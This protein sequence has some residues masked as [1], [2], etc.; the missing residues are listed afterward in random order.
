ML[1]ELQVG[2]ARSPQRI[3]PMCPVWVLVGGLSSA[4]A[5]GMSGS[6]I[7]IMAGFDPALL[8]GVVRRKRAGRLFRML[9]LIARR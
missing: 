7:S 2:S 9:S 3:P 5:L 8:T 6:R 1:V 4:Q